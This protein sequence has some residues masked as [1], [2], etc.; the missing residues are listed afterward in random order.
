M[1][2]RLTNSPLPDFLGSTAQALAITQPL[3]TTLVVAATLAVAA[4]LGY[5][6]A[7]RLLI[8]ILQRVTVRSD[9]QWVD[10]LRGQRVFYRLSH[11]VPLLIVRAGLPYLPALP[12]SITLLLQRVI[13]VWMVIAVARALA[14]ALAAYGEVRTRSAR[15]G[16]RPIKGYLQ[17]ATLILYLLAAV[18]ALGVLLDRD[19][20]LLLT[21]IGA[22][23]A[24]LLLIFQNTILSLVAGIQLTNN[25]LIRVGDWIEMPDMNADGDV[26]EIAL[27]TVT[28]QNWDKT[29]T[30]IPTHSF[31]GKSFKNWRGMQASG[32]RR[33]KRSLDLDVSTIRF[34]A[35]HDIER[36][37]KFALLRPYFEEKRAEISAWTQEHPDAQ[38]DAV[39]SRR[40]TNVGTFRA[41]VTR[42]LRSHPRIAQDMT[43]LVRQLQ[44]GPS[45]L[46]LELYVF[47]NDVRW[48]VYEGVQA[49]VFDHLIAILPEF[50]LRLFQ[51]PSGS[52]IGR[53]APAQQSD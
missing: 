4:Y 19:P 44:P 11:F 8:G 28:V 29:F 31:L 35:E 6:L 1:D 16:Q 50:E 20:L 2:E 22:A 5:M 39:N 14:S 32:G 52:D 10:A 3:L 9:D 49:D 51:A 43:F 15:P 48:A 12:A 23:S 46:P 38:D 36:L 41:Y 40:L 24:V 53:L 18:V 21:G 30:I 17:M 33:I 42:Y 26:T 37:S 45:G 34:L 25:D 47:V 7:R 27:N 13:T